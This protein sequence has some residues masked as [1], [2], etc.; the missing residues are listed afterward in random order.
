MSDVCR[1][2]GSPS[3]VLSVSVCGGIGDK[4]GGGGQS[5]PE[6][7]NC[8]SQFCLYEPMIQ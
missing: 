8:S 7:T 1:E 2:G 4:G 3:D 6:K 5:C